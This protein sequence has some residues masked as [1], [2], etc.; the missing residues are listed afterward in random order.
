MLSD[1][2]KHVRREREDAPS[3]DSAGLFRNR[4]LLQESSSVQIA[5]RYELHRYVQ[6]RGKRAAFFGVNPSTAD[7]EIDDHTVR[8]WIGF[9]RVLGFRKF[10][11]GNAFAMRATDV[12]E[13][14]GNFSS[15][16][17]IG[18]END[19][20][21]EKIIDSADILI[22][23]WG[24]ISKVP[25]HLRP[26]FEVMLEYMMASDK[27]MAHFGRTADGGYKHVLTLG[28]DTPLIRM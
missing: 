16:D 20:Y 10:I 12:R 28:Y 25:P 21:L 23:C 15:R 7:D 6:L 8:K 24:R 4:H 9:S 13:L 18:P 22:P 14:R 2:K 17:I 11:V 27:P 3:N 1:N 5:Y 26:R 19:A